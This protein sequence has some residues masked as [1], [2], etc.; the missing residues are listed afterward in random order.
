[1][2]KKKGSTQ[3]EKLVQANAWITRETREFIKKIAKRERRSYA[4][5]LAVIL[6]SYAEC[7][8]A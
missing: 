8:R 1:M 6:E 5:H 3:R 2:R 4:G 7:L